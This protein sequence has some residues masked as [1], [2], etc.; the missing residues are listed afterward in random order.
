MVRSE[1]ICGAVIWEQPLQQPHQRLH[2]PVDHAN[3]VVV[4]LGV[5]GA[6]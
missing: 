4:A 6:T 2:T 5:R 1:K 3:V